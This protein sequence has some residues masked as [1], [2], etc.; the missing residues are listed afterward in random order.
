MLVV[1]SISA[2]LRNQA[3]EPC[4][5][6]SIASTFHQASTTALEIIPFQRSEMAS[7]ITIGLGAAVAAF[8][9]CHSPF[10]PPFLQALH[11]QDCANNKAGPRWS[12]RISQ[13]A[14]RSWSAHSI[15]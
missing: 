7:V 5:F 11:P 4:N 1:P 10:L 2:E 12:G 9:V 14:R 13:F 6:L 8:L 15:L 3:P